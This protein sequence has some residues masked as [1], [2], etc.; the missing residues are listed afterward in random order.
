MYGNNYILNILHKGKF[1]NKIIDVWYPRPDFRRHWR[2]SKIH[3]GPLL[4]LLKNARSFGAIQ[5]GALLSGVAFVKGC[6]R[7]KLLPKRIA[8]CTCFFFG[9]HRR[10]VRTTRARRAGA[11][12]SE[13]RFVK[14]EGG[15][16]S[17]LLDR[18]IEQAEPSPPP[19]WRGEKGSGERTVGHSRTFLQPWKLNIEFMLIAVS[20]VETLICIDKSLS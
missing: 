7:V 3:W 2:M 16:H 14:C 13:P 8:V 18:P 20:W 11:A 12:S 17:L 4:S 6:L 10:V 1:S 5:R 15:L 19:P 9:S